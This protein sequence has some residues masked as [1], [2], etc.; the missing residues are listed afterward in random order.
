MQLG[1]LFVLLRV[2]EIEPSSGLP[3]ILPLVFGGFVVHALLP[4]RW[5]LQFFLLLSVAAFG[6]VLGPIAGGML[7][8]L[9]LVLIG[10]CHLPIAFLIRVLLLIAIAGVLA[11]IHAGWMDLP[12]ALASAPDAPSLSQLVLPVLG[13]MFMFRLVIYLYDLRHEQ[14]APADKESARAASMPGSVWARLSYFFL[15]PNICFLLFPVVDY[16]TYR[17]TYY[18]RDANGIYEKGVWWICLGLIHLLLYRLVYHYLVPAPEDVQ[19][20]GGVVRFMVASYLVYLRVVGQFHLIT[21]LLCLFGFN[22]PPAHHFYLL[23]SSFTDFWRR[24]RIDW[25]DFMVKVFYYPTLVPLQ[26]KWGPPLALVAGTIVVFVTTWLLHSYQWF[27]LRGDFRLSRNDAVFWTIIG[28]CVLV[29]S[30]LEARRSRARAAGWSLG[31]SVAYALKVMGMFAFMCVLWSYWSSPSLAVWLSYLTAARESGAGA[32]V[33]LAGALL[34]VGGVG[35]LA[36]FIAA[37]VAGA[38]ARPR[39]RREPESRAGFRWRPAVVL[40]VAT[41]LLL[42]SVPAT[43]RVLKGPILDVVSTLGTNRLNVFDQEMED[44]GYYEV[45]LDEPRST[46]AWITAPGPRVPGFDK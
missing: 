31:P 39:G 28:G 23:A 35:V 8:V 32:Y 44:R 43:N 15:L 45:L 1:L 33:A 21:G 9:G 3:R 17:R 18:D 7:V 34:G 4:L 2:L 5:R 22:L 41:T 36:T 37:R 42:A 19:G 26:R 6:L 12:T 25:K 13:S 24:A 16:R 20:L 40:A 29:N 46:A 27:W 11:A 38:S 30:L 14:R 10:V